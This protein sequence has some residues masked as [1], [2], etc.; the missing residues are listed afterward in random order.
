MK[1]TIKSVF[2]SA[3]LIA[4]TVIGF[5]GVASANHHE[6]EKAAA[7]D[8]SA[9]A[10]VAAS[11]C[12]LPAAPIIPDGNVASEDE[13]VAAQ[14]AMKMFQDTIIKSRECIAGKE[15]F[16][17]PD[18]EGSDEKAAALVAQYNVTVD[19][20]AKVAEEFNAAVRAF[21]ARQ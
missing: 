13:L 1:H 11:N 4:F 8:E 12:E 17:D 18:A 9:N 5:T 7:M 3:L 2:L 15:Q 6:A 19:A 20:E 10:E 21:K 16:I 14:R